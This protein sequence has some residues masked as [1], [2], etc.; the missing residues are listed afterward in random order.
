MKLRLTPQFLYDPNDV[1]SVTPPAP[2]PPA[3][4]AVTPPAPEPAAPPATAPWQAD[5]E[6]YFEDPTARAAADRYLRERVQPHV[7]RLEQDTAPARQLY[8]DLQESPEEAYLRLTEALWGEEAVQQVLDAL[9][10]EQQQPAAPAAPAPAD[11]APEV[12]EAVEHY[13]AQKRQEAYEAEIK[14]V[15]PLVGDDF[16]ANEFH[17]FVLA[18]EGNFDTAV[19]GY[20]QWLTAVRSKYGPAAPEQPAAPPALGT[21]TGGGTPPPPVA[22]KYDSIDAALEATMDEI[23]SQNA[24]TTVGQV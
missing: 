15:K 8:S 4:A 6:Q 20:Q 16:D 1:P 3:P 21:H 17:P 23:R 22:P 12:K 19:A 10:T 11:L 9:G 13:Q 24:P 18:A 14:R 7:T 2:E 5:L